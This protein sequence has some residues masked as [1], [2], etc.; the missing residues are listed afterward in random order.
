M[1][2]WVMWDMS[3][4]GFFVGMF[5]GKKD[6]TKNSWERRLYRKGVTKF[7]SLF[8]LYTFF[9]AFDLKKSHSNSKTMRILFG[10]SSSKRWEF[11]DTCAPWAVKQRGRWFGRLKSHPT[12]Y[13]GERGTCFCFKNQPKILKN[14]QI[15]KKRNTTISLNRKNL[16][17]PE[18]KNK[19]QFPGKE[20]WFKKKQSKDLAIL[21]LFVLSVGR[22][23]W[24]DFPSCQC[25]VLSH[26]NILGACSAFLE[27][28]IPAGSH[29][30]R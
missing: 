20:T 23:P 29:L 19:N 2:P 7:P 22:W 27:T 8:D 9:S 21:S 13:F 15:L 10:S 4:G 16:N 18:R 5:G 25:E 30:A 28:R 6:D 17:T 24:A 14:K 12:G 11:V 1:S 26:P 3:L